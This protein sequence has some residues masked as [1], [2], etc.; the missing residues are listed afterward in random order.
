MPAEPR[1]PVTTTPSLVP[2]LAVAIPLVA[3]THSL[4][5]VL[6]SVT[7]LALAT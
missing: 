7:L 4:V 5:V 6:V 2:V 3:P 1:P